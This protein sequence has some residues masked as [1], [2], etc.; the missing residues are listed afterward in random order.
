MSTLG[1]GGET[2]FLGFGGRLETGALGTAD[3]GL[4]GGS[5]SRETEVEFF[6]LIAASCLEGFFTSKMVGL[7]PV[8]G[9]LV[10]D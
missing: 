1:L 6:G 9:G 3:L 2:S 7:K 5:C 8:V 10:L 4:E